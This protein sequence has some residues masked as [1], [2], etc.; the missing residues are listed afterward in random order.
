M[1]VEITTV[2]ERP[3]LRDALYAMPDSWPEFVLHDQVGWAH[4]GRLAD[5]F[6][7]LTLVGT[8]DG[9]VVVRGFSVPFAIAAPDREQLPATGWDQAL[10]WAFSDHRRGVV[11]DTV[12]AIE[13]A[14][15]PDRQRA[16]PGDARRDARQR[17]PSRLSRARRAGTADPW[18]RA[19][20][21]P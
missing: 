9:E 10:L 21:S 6:P 19:L 1:P 11:P 4:F 2:A 3:Q 12:S 16:V 7:E 15:R 13:V 8:D 18:L 14:V 17:A 20:N 5:T